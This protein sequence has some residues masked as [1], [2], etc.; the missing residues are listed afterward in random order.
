MHK[1][2]A[3]L[4]ILS[5]AS[6]ARA[7]ESLDTD[8]L[9]EHH[10]AAPNAAPVTGA[11]L[12]ANDR[13]WPYQVELLQSTRAGLP[14]GSVGV[15]I[16]VEAGGVARIDFGRDGLHDLPVDATD[17]VERANRVRSGALDKM[18]PNF[19]FALGPRLLDPAGEI[20]RPFSFAT[21]SEKPGFVCVFADPDAQGFP[22]LAAALAPIRERHGVTTILFPQGEQPDAKTRQ[23]LRELGWE[24]PF[25]YDHLSEAYTRTLL[26]S[27]VRSPAVMLQTNEGRVVLESAWRADLVLDLTL[28]LDRAFGGTPATSAAVDRR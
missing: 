9:P 13:F 18:A 15:L 21:A 25:V 14:G 22:A 8:G 26:S 3:L 27:G 23:R 5:A 2:L 1:L 10:A 11:N 24:V 16:R 19:L 17:L 7:V 12:L 6:A 28:A 20:L 4:A